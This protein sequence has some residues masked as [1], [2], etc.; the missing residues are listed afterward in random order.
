MPKS[1]S[2]E[3][4]ASPPV[5]VNVVVVERPSRSAAG[6][7]TAPRG[8]TAIG[9]TSLLEGSWTYECHAGEGSAAATAGMAKTVAPVTATADKAVSACRRVDVCLEAGERVMAGASKACGD[10]M[11]TSRTSRRGPEAS[12]MKGFNPHVMASITLL[13]IVNAASTKEWTS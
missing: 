8:V 12:S 4:G 13:S 10:G 2:T 1:K 5:V 7:A 9:R 6:C 3:A 11:E